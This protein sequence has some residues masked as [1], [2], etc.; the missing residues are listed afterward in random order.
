MQRLTPKKTES[1]YVCV[2]IPRAEYA[3]L[4]AIALA[5]GAAMH[6]VITGLINY[7]EE[8]EAEYEAD[9]TE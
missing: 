4:R 6:K 9:D 1:P 8:N 7:Y 5:E 3:R 2:N